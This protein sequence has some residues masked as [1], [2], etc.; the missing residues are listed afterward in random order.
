MGENRMSERKLITRFTRMFGCDT[1]RIAK[2]GGLRFLV[3]GWNRWSVG[4]WVKTWVTDDG[5][6]AHLDF[7]FNYVEEQVIASGGTDAELLASAKQY[8]ALTGAL[9]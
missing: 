5:V 1:A 6:V 4:E 2:A 8:Q 7:N 3:I 9:A